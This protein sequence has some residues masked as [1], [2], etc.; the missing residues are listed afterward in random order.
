MPI[1]HQADDPPW[2]LRHFDQL[3]FELV[4]EAELE[5]LRSRSHA[6]GWAPRI[7]QAGFSLAEHE[8]LLAANAAEIAEFRARREAAF[9]IERGAWKAAAALAKDAA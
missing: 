1:W 8:T 5:E 2:R 6:G 4:A 3:R 9:S 7:E